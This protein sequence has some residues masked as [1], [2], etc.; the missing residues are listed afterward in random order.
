MMLRVE[1]VWSNYQ[2]VISVPTKAL[3]TH[4]VVKLQVLVLS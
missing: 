2:I 4:H 1:S 3:L